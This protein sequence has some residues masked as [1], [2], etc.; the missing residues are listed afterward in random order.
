[1]PLQIIPTINLK[2]S[3]RVLYLTSLFPCWSETF[4]VREIN[5]LVRMG[6]DVRIVSLKYPVEK[7][8][9]SDAQALLSRVVYPAHG[10]N[11][12]CGA[13]LE[14]FRHPWREITSLFS[15]VRGLFSHPQ[16]LAKSLVVWWRTLALLP[17]V[18]ALNPNHIHAH[19]ATYPSTSAMLMAKRLGKPYSFTAHAHDIFLED[20]LLLQKMRTAAFGIT[21]SEFN[22]QYLAKKISP[23]ALQCMGVVHCGVVPDDFVF[24][25]EARQQGLILAVGRL[26]EIKGFVH[27]IDACQLLLVRGVEFKCNIIGEG[28]LRVPLQQHIELTGLTEHVTLLGAQKQEMVRTYLSRASMF[29]LP[30]V[31]TATGDRDGIPVA[32][33]EAMAVGL[34]VVST[35]VSGIP[36][37]IAHGQCGL[38]AEPKDAADLSQCIE[39][40]L[41]NPKLARQF[42]LQ[43]RTVIEK[44]FDIAIEATKLLDAMKALS[45]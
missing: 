28:P 24:S 43:A 27:L 33:M 41:L 4:I 3:M 30:S 38:L 11:A 14:C 42:A 34:P 45:T 5:E 19:W 7:M 29:V 15:L 22:R 31:V 21:I 1:M 23:L 16:A 20:H 36:E 32:L 9:Q 40:L 18:R 10:A 37:L 6:V 13:L 39:Q 2:D 44:E 17:V 8:V 35:R 26:D 25:S 12:W